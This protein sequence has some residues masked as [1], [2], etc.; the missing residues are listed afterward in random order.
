[1]HEIRI[2]NNANIELRAEQKL[3]QHIA[4]SYWF[5]PI[6]PKHLGNCLLCSSLWHCSVLSDLMLLYRPQSI[7]LVVLI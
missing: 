2:Q 3:A 1:M 5:E 6:K 7:I 4:I